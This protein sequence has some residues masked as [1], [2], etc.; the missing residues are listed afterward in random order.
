MTGNSSSM[1]AF[2]LRAWRITLLGI[3][4]AYVGPRALQAADAQLPDAA[5]ILDKYVEVTGGLEAYEKIHNRT[6]KLRLIHVGMGFEDSVVEYYASPNKRYTILESDAMDGVRHGTDGD[7]VW[8]LSDQTGALIEDGEARAAALDGAAFDRVWNWRAYYKDV[9]CAAEEVIDEQECYK[10]VLTPNHG[11]PETRYYAKDTNLM[12]R[13]DIARLSSHM[14]TLRAQLSLSDYRRVDGLLLP[15]DIRH[16]SSM[17][18]G[19]REMR[20][21][22]E[23]VEHNVDLPADRFDPPPEI[24]SAASAGGL[25]SLGQAIKNAVSPGSKNTSGGSGAGCGGQQQPT[26]GQR[27]GCGG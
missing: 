12:I 18:G 27:P 6:A 19:N 23:S 11:E 25:A 2:S 1:F 13:A 4:A 22:V 10:L 20:L 21:I 17:C 9:E 7:V 3:L 14:P 15:H 8:Y 26:G 16:V 5:T 24:R